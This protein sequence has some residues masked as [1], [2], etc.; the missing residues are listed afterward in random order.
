M[1]LTA[2]FNNISVI[3]WRS[4]LLMEE[5]RLPGENNIPAASHI[6]LYRVH[7]TMRGIRI[8]NVSGDK[9]WLHRQFFFFFSFAFTLGVQ[10]PLRIWWCSV[11]HPWVAQVVIKPIPYDHDHGGPHFIWIAVIICIYIWCNFYQILIKSKSTYLKFH[12]HRGD[13]T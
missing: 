13:V 2:I 1:V 5:T 7:L 8:H 6:M 12:N 3:S 9:H 10:I 11:G 4:E